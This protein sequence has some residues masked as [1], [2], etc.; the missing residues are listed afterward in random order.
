MVNLRVQKRLSAA[1]M[2]CGKKRVWMD[3]NEAN[4]ISHANS[5]KP[6]S[7]AS[8]EMGEFKGE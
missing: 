1:V 8:G 7:G 4:E 5:S 2:K 3:P 6:K